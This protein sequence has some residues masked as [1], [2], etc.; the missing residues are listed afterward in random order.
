MSQLGNVIMSSAPPEQTNEA[1]GFKEQRR[2][3]ALPRHGADRLR[4]AARAAE[5]IQQPD[6]AEPGSI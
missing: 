2:T 6:R 1:E 5:R 4:P 3:S